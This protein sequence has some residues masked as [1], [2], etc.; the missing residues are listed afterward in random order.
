MVETVETQRFYAKDIIAYNVDVQ[1]GNE[2]YTVRRKQE[3]MLG[4]YIRVSVNV[5]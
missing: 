2:I 3:P 1:L 4:D 5:Q